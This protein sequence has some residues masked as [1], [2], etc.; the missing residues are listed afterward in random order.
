MCTIRNLNSFTTIQTQYVV[1]LKYFI[2]KPVTLVTITNNDDYYSVED[3]ETIAR[4]RSD[5]WVVCR[6][7]CQRQFFVVISQKN[8]NFTEINGQ[9]NLLWLTMCVCIL[10]TVAYSLQMRFEDFVLKNLLI[11]SFL[12]NIV[13][14][15][16]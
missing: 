9:Y 15:I 14:I 13:M 11:F 10:M 7:S 4:T 12:I 8:A 2:C 16:T 3:N 1:P 5:C 6:K